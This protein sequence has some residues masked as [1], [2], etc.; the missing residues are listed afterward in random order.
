MFI[1]TILLVTILFTMPGCARFR[2]ARLEK[3]QTR[4]ASAICTKNAIE[5]QVHEAINVGKTLAARDV[6]SKFVFFTTQ[7]KNLTPDSV[8]IKHDDIYPRPITIE[9]IKKQLPLSYG[10]FFIPA[11]TL[12]FA[13]FL[14]LW[15]ICLPLAGLFSL[16]GINQSQ[17]ATE[18]ILKQYASFMIPNNTPITVEPNSTQEML[19]VFDRNTYNGV[20][21]ITVSKKNTHAEYLL[22]L[23]KHREVNFIYE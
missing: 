11:A 4:V 8:S 14:F 22:E 7:I 6:S 2:P 13:G 17:K 19:L 10:C 20:I 3:T 18:G 5:I 1:K 15:K 21:N 12:T 9:D 16:F 23:T